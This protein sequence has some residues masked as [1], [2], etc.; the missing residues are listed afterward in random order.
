VLYRFLDVHKPTLS[1]LRA[2]TIDIDKRIAIERSEEVHWVKLD[3]SAQK[4]LKDSTRECFNSIDKPEPTSPEVNKLN[5]TN[6]QR[7]NLQATL[8]DE[9]AKLWESQSPD[10]HRS[11]V[12]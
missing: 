11:G 4:R 9:V 6:R 12:N 8:W 1:L 3:E 2:P 5:P 7:C 10:I